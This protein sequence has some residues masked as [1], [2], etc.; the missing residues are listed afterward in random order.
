MKRIDHI[1]VQFQ[2]NLHI[3]DKSRIEDGYPDPVDQIRQDKYTEMPVPEGFAQG[4][5][6]ILLHRRRIIIILFIDHKSRKD[7]A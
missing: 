1:V 6:S 7:H 4:T 3:V 5:E 2:E